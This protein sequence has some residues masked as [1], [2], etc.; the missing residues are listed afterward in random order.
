M[1]EI[2]KRGRIER[3]FVW[4]GGGLF[5]GSLA[6]TAWCYAVVWSQVLPFTGWA[7]VL[8]DA[9]LFGLFAVHHSVLAR[10]WAKRAL[11]A[12]VPERLV[13]SFYVWVASL[14]LIAVLAAWREVGGVIYHTSG[15]LRIVHAA[16]Q[17]L[18]L[19]LI[20]GAVRAIDGLELAGIREDSTSALQ[21]HGPYHLVRHPLYLG[22]ILIAFGAAFMT[23]DRLAFAVITSL[24]LF[25][26]VPWEERS[27]ERSFGDE[28]ARYKQRVRW[29]IVPYVY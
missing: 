21:T 9:M 10:M 22:W 20:A 3:P 26:A 12:V 5:V 16:I 24:Y 17:L 11:S 18:G 23:G 7:V 25:L 28:Y 19:W 4:A 14:L 29:R 13:R 8:Y 2:G 27:L 1:D 6:L 15:V